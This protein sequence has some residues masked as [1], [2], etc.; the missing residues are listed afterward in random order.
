M[1]RLC[2]RSALFVV[3]VGL[4]SCPYVIAEQPAESFSIVL[5]P[6]T[7]FYSEKF[8]ETYLVQTEWIKQHAEADNTKF[9]IHL[10]DLVQTA[11]VEE[12]WQ[13]C[14]K[15]QSVLDGVVPYSVLPGN[16]DSV[17]GKDGG[18]RAYDLYNK[19]FPPCRFEGCEWYGGHFGE[20]NIANYCCFCAGGMKFMVVSLAYAPNDE[21]LDWA[22]QVVA[23]HP[24]HRVI[25]ATHAY[26]NP[27]G[28]LKP[29]QSIWNNLVSK[30]ENI[31][32]VVC[33]HIGATAHLTSTNDAGGVVHEILCDYQSKPNGGNGWLQT[34]RF[35]PAENTILVKAY[36]P[37][38]DQGNDSLQHTY[39]LQYDMSGRERPQPE[40]EPK[41]E[42][43]PQS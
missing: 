36:S 27:K 21:I 34:L 22:G 15:A 24:E 7:Q 39:P 9:V 17:E 35:V 4:L 38:L 20:T 19:Y 14:D 5:L 40:A 26:M 30:H 41:V 6:D 2:R 12:Q 8:S 33:G 3:A 28:H 18:P 1:L 32:M 42:A 13:N 16:H 43:T 25:V 10:G 31:F 11:N 37:L 29:T 23:E